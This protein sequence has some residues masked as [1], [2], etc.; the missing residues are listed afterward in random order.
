MAYMSLEST[1][2]LTRS[3]RSPGGRTARTSSIMHVLSAKAL[4][5][6]DVDEFCHL[7]DE[8]ESGTLPRQQLFGRTV[9][10][11]FFQSSTRTRL[12]FESATVALGAH[13]IGM[14]DMTASRTNS[15]VRESLEDCAAVISRLCDAIVV[16]HFESD[17][18]VRMAEK[19]IVPVINAGDGWNEH[20][21]QALIDIFAMRRGL[22]TIRGKS[23][24]FGGDPRGRVIRSLVQLLRHEAPREVVFCAPPHY[25]V[26][27]D[28]VA[29]L[30]EYQ[31]RLRLIGN[32]EEALR[33]SDAITMA[34]YDMSAIG[35]PPA[36][37][38][39]SPHDTRDSFVITA[40]KI[41]RTRSKALIYHP[42][43]RF[44]EIHPSC[45]S[46]PNAMYFEQVR[47]SRY[48]R[49]AVLYRV[50]AGN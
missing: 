48:M 38:Y 26:P 39:V 19:S 46:L 31:I 30:A 42:L 45:D 14:E 18:A 3:A 23:I 12:G 11:L 41:E 4:T 5:I 25:P 29:A 49:M 21:T 27:E 33:H 47:L 37:D 9:A 43:P 36:S 20:P 13:A 28:L 6:D 7:A 2:G 1:G 50:L 40:E 16:R 15:S 35:E 22:G 34:P 8:F 10:L 44:D 32:I 17:A 24:A